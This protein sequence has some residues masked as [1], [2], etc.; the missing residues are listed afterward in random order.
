MSPTNRK[1]APA[2]GPTPRAGDAVVRPRHDE[3]TVPP[4][5]QRPIAV[6]LILVP[7]L[8]LVIA[9]IG[10][11]FLKE[12]SDQAALAEHTLNYEVQA[13]AIDQAHARRETE[14]QARRTAA[15]Q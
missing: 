8:V 3:A 12:R 5:L 14:E 4:L 2:D 9:L 10:G 15:M 13:E 11:L 7:M 1:A 6:W